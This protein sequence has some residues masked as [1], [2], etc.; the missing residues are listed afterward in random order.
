M[1]AMAD[2]KPA[3]AMTKAEIYKL[4]DLDRPFVTAKERKESMT[5]TGKFCGGLWGDLERRGGRVYLSDWT[6]AFAGEN[7]Q[8]TIASIFFLFFACS[9]LLISPGGKGRRSA[10]R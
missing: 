4:K 6:D 3:S 7:F 9:Y 2:M 8:K 1:A 10:G 5:F